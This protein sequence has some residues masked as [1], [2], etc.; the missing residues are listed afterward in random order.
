MTTEQIIE[1]ISKLLSKLADK[2]FVDE[3]WEIQAVVDREFPDEEVSDGQ[4]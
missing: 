2:G 4:D 3:S 1:E